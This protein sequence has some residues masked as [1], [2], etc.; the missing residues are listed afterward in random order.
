MRAC[1]HACVRA[2]VCAR[3]RACVRARVR[4]CVRTCVRTCVRLCV[5]VCARACVRACARVWLCGCMRARVC[6]CVGVCRV[7]PGGR[8]TNG[9]TILRMKW[10]HALDD[11]TLIWLHQNI[12][13]I[14][15]FA[16][17]VYIIFVLDAL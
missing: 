13:Y 4:A 3:V 16:N 11:V 14:N 7:S 15:D 12:Q 1:V 17:F 8:V 2:S 5:R 10:R 6:G 9:G